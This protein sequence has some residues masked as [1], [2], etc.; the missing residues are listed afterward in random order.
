MDPADRIAEIYEAVAA[1][2]DRARSRACFERPYLERVL[3]HFGL[4]VEA[5]AGS[6]VVRDRKGAAAVVTDLGGLW[7]EAERLAGRPLDPLDPGLVEALSR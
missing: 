3:A 5:W 4:S 6:Y 2:Y 7:A 1:Q